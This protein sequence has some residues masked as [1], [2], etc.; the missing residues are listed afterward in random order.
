MTVGESERGRRKDRRRGLSSPRT[1]V[2][3]SGPG[4]EGLG[5]LS[6]TPAPLPASEGVPVSNHDRRPCVVH[7]THRFPDLHLDRVVQ[8]E[9]KRRERD[10]CLKTLLESRLTALLH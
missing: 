7:P 1:L 6:D 9:G 10:G 8:S 4:T 2:V 3:L 5:L